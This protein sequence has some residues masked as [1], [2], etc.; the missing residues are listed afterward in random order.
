MT[1]Q[2]TAG[3]TI[4][5]LADN[6]FIPQDEANTDFVAYKAW[7]S[8][9]NTPLPDPAAQPYTWEQAIAKR[10][11]L[12]SSS[13]WTMIPGCTVD[14]HDW[15]VYRQIL[16]DIPQ[17]YKG[18]DPLVIVWPEPPSTTGPNT[19]AAEISAQMAEEAAVKIDEEETEG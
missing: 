12:L 5:R 18:L 1:Y 6:A 8:A 14:Q 15:A 10:D 11:Q 3:D 13:D 7:L 2:L 16:R 4:L 19:K 17:T 9:G